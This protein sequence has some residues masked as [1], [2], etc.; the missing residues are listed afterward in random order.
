MFRT[1]RNSK[2]IAEQVR[3]RTVITVPHP[4]WSQLWLFEFNGDRWVASDNA[5]VGGA[6]YEC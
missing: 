1:L 6:D 5:F 4:R 2:D 3:G